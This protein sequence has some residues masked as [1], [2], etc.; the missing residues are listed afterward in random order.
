MAAGAGR[1]VA[2]DRGLFTALLR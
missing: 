2:Q 1:A